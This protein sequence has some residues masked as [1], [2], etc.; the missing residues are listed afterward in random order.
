MAETESPL[1]NLTDI[2]RLAGVS[3]TVVSN[4]RKRHT[5]FPQPAAE[6]ASGPVFN[7]DEIA[8]WLERR[9]P[10]AAKTVQPLGFEAKLWQ[11]ADA[12]RNSMDPAE[13]KHVVLGLIFLK[14][15]SDAFEDRRAALTAAT[16]DRSSN[17]YCDSDG[18]RRHMLEDR[19]Q[20]TAENVFW[21][22]EIARWP[23][24]QENAKQPNVGKLLDD[25]MESV[26][27]DNPRLK[28]VL[29]RDYARP[30]LDWQSLG[31]LIDLI[32]SIGL[33]G[34]DARSKDVLGR[35]YEYFLG[36]F[37]SAE[38]KGG[39]EFYTPQPIVRLLVE[40]IE[41]F[42]GRV[43]DPCFGSGGMFVQSVRF[44]EAHGGRRA[45]LSIFG[46]ESNP[47]TW[48]LGQMN[49]AIRGI[50][51]DLGREN[52]DSF[53][54]DLHKDL[55]ADFI[56]ANPPFNVSDW[57]GGLLREDVRWKYGVPPVGNAN[58]AWIQ[59]FIHHLAPHGVA[60][61]VM[62]N[63]SLSSQQSGEGEIR[64]AIV[65][66]DLV[67]CIVALPTQLFYSTPIPVCLWFLAKDRSA[68]GGYRDRR[69]EILFIDARSIGQLVTRVHRVLM[70]QEIGR[71]A[72]TYH[73]WRGEPE[74][75]DYGD[76]PGFCRSASLSDV[77]EN[78]YMLTPG[79]FV[80]NNEPEI[81]SE[82][83]ADRI[84]RL[85]RDLLSAF[86]DDQHLRSTLVSELEGLTNGK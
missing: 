63:G 55:R 31:Q 13:Y 14:Y 69:G 25:A 58:Y 70:D 45:R 82:A 57:K 75:G 76:V 22:P 4:W 8:A 40:M 2:A 65:E 35:V 24:L 56:L 37:A 78:Q 7:R 28:G 43:Y 27:H 41:P 9:R 47:T 86:A 83:P 53:R 33:G 44:L 32:G 15:I 61:F 10:R 79:R 48:K 29:P 54:S 39:G 59:H 67:D 26:E 81:A 66:A 20:Y 11:A 68:A 77:G 50:D 46:Q 62:A 12:L 17:L 49:L 85:A 5:D 73:A 18:E 84:Q 42:D 74:A 71:I 16:F 1:L 38:G 30:T 23:W 34:A 64:K 72:T 6:P 60:G 3:R 51:A 21:V 80:G 36:R 19:D 52:A